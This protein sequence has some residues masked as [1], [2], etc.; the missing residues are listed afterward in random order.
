LRAETAKSGNR[1]YPA[2]IEK[3]FVSPDPFVRLTSAP[4]H[5]LGGLGID[6]ILQGTTPAIALQ[7]CLIVATPP[8]NG[9]KN[10]TPQAAIDLISW[11]PLQS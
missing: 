7:A 1:R 11:T 5:G 8:Y 3:S 10:M 2:A 4:S 6:R 9:A